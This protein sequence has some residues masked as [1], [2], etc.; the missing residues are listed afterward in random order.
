MTR[1]EYDITTV[2]V[3]GCAFVIAHVIAAMLSHKVHPIALLGAI[4]L[5]VAPFSVA[6]ELAFSAVL[7]Y[8]RMYSIGLSVVLAIL[9]LIHI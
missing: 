3:I 2:L 7:K 5:A 9:S 4:Y 6:Q 1:F 8:A